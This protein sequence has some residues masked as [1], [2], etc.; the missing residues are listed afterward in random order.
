[1]SVAWS[2][3]STAF[4][5]FNNGLHSG[6]VWLRGW[7]SCLSAPPCFH[8]AETGPSLSLQRSQLSLPKQT[9]RKKPCWNV[10]T[11]V[12]HENQTNGIKRTWRKSV[13]ATIKP[14]GHRPVTLYSPVFNS[15]IWYKNSITFLTLIKI[16][17]N[18]YNKY[19][20]S[21][22]WDKILTN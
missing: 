4:T 3:S 18:Q 8:T 16:L 17:K 12:R 1:M 9:R 13:C 7:D 2:G 22:N 15:S 10:C 5:N 20:D 19:L 6:L 11:I 14:L 21:K